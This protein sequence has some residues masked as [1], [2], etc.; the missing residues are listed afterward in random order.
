VNR[1]RNYTSTV[2]VESSINWIEKRLAAAGASH[3]L[4]E[5]NST[6]QIEMLVFTTKMPD[7]RMIPIRLPSRTKSVF[8]A[9][10]REVRRPH[11]GT[12]DKIM[13]QALRTS[14]KLMSDWVDMQVTLIQLQQAEF[15]EVFLPYVSDA[16]GQ[17]TFYESLK[18]NGFKALP[19]SGPEEK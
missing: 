18:G 11:R 10:W 7:G 4:K 17:M 12:K 9:L 14:W 19:F 2:P 15:L 13:D 5:Y 6:G 8:E 3:I 1:I 16:R